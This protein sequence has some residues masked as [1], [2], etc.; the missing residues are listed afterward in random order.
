MRIWYSVF[1][2]NMQLV[3]N[4]NGYINN[5]KVVVPCIH[6]ALNIAIRHVYG[7]HILLYS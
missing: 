6:E 2:S 1:T 3:E 4:I 5:L 7:D